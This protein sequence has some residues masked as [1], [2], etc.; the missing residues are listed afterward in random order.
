MLKPSR[1]HD[2]P[3]HSLYPT[4][5][6]SRD[7]NFGR[8]DVFVYLTYPDVSKC[9]S[10][11]GPWQNIGH[12]R[13]RQFRGSVSTIPSSTPPKP[14][15]ATTYHTIHKDL[16]SSS[17]LEADQKVIAAHGCYAMTATTALTAQN[18]TGVTAIH[19]VPPAFLRQQLDA[20]FDDMGADVVKTGMLASKETISAVAGALEARFAGPLVIDPVMVATTGAEL[21]PPAALRELRERLLPRATVLTPNIP[22]ARM[23]LADSGGG[24]VRLENVDDLVTVAGKLLSLGPEWVVVKGGHVPFNRD[25]V[26]AKTEAERQIVVDVLVGKMGQCVRIE[27]GWKDSTSTHGTGCSLA[28]ESTRSPKQGGTRWRRFFEVDLVTAA[29]ASNLAKGME[30]PGAVRAAC[31]YVEAGIRTAPGFGRGN[32]PLDHFHST[33]TLPFTPWV[34]RITET[35]LGLLTRM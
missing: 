5:A 2:T 23:L 30:V 33:Y 22:E 9:S 26:L 14:P 11:D 24:E 8:A 12:R 17:G 27:T 4:Q 3:P 1:A 25:Y 6:K 16:H 19:Q 34:P 15:R 7:L 32:G 28:C 20:V 21:L 29:I 10:Q 31:R 18:T 13:L 35:L